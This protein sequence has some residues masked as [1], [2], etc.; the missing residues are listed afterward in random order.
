MVTRDIIH[1][2]ISQQVTP[3]SAAA[4]RYDANNRSYLYRL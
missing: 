4:N 3:A 1:P 2:A